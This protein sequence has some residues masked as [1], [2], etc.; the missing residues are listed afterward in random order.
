MRQVVSLDPDRFEKDEHGQLYWKGNKL[1]MGSQLQTP[2]IPMVVNIILLA[3]IGLIVVAVPLASSV[4]L[5]DDLLIILGLQTWAQLIAYRIVA[6]N[7]CVVSNSI[8]GLF[9]FGGPQAT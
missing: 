6:Q 4:A 9:S 1:V 8:L 5:G 7:C 2:K 3:V